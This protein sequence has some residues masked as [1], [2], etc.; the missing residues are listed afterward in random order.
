MFVDYKQLNKLTIKNA[1]PCHAIRRCSE[2]E[3]SFSGSSDPQSSG[4]VKRRK[5]VNVEEPNA[6]HETIS[7]GD[8]GCKSSPELRRLRS[9]WGHDTQT[10][11]PK[12]R[13]NGGVGSLHHGVNSSSRLS[14]YSFA[15]SITDIHHC[16]NRL[17]LEINDA[18]SVRIW[19]LG[20]NLG[21]QCS[22]DDGSLVGELDRLEV[23]DKDDKK[24]S[25]VGSVNELP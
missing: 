13:S 21:M 1:N 14:H 7:S 23:R 16:N 11:Q 22:G 5:E 6:E 3:G 9:T 18:E 17:K 19:E 2:G 12:W 20:R 24:V 8:V 10:A 4:S 15:E 25:Q